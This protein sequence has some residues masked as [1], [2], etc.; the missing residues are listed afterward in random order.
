MAAEPVLG[1]SQVQPTLL[2]DLSDPAWGGGA[3]RSDTRRGS[4]PTSCGGPQAGSCR[5]SDLQTGGTMDFFLDDEDDEVFDDED[6]DEDAD[7]EDTD[8]D[9]DGDEDEE[10]EGWQVSTILTS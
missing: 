8:E 9:E 7:S 4:R 3:R 1:L 5:I 6:F 2:D 10:V